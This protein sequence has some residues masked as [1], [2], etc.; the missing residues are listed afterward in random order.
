MQTKENKAMILAAGLGSRLGPLTKNRPKALVEWEGRPLLEHV[1]LKLKSEGF[2]EIIINIHH[3]AEMIRDFVDAKDR[4][5]IGI[6]FSLEEELLDTGGGIRKASWFFGEE[7]FLVY[8]VDIL[9]S[10]DLQA[11]MDAHKE[12]GASVTLA[13][14]DRPTTR[15]LLMNDEG[16]LKGWRDN[17]SGETILV[18]EGVDRLIPIAYS[19]TCVMSPEVQK[20]FP[21]EDRFPLMPWLLMLAEKEAVRLYRHDHDSWMDMGKPEVYK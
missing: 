8:N 3:F 12:G 15:S 7:D 1:I 14:K 13:V 17:R 4:F 2:R 19:A 18:D 11:L 21:E 20:L 6:E 5:G 9:S 16:L 10:I